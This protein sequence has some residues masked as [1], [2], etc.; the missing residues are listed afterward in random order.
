M[1]LTLILSSITI[2]FIPRVKY[3]GAVHREPT[4][5]V[6]VLLARSQT[7]Q[8]VLGIP[9]PMLGSKWGTAHGC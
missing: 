2:S 7:R 4:Y 3:V 9:F 5:C 1:S 6:L 8:E